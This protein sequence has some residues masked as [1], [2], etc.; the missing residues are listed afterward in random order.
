MKRGLYPGDVVR[1]RSLREV[2]ATLDGDGTLQ[3]LP[4]MPEMAA[5]CGKQFRVYRRLEKTCV[6]GYGARVLAD[7]VILAEARC[8]G[9][10]HDGCQRHCAL[11]WKEAW[12]QRV[13]RGAASAAAAQA[14]VQAGA[15]PAWRT[16]SGPDRYF[17]QS[18]ELGKATKYLFPISVKRCTAEYCARNFD[19]RKC[20][21]FLWIPLVV[22]IKTKLFGLR[23]VQPVGASDQTPAEELGL[24]PGEWIEVK[25]PAEIGLTLDRRGRNRGLAFTPQML[26]FCGRRYRV[27]S[28]VDRAI[29]EETGAMRQ[30]KNTVI[31]EEAVC[32]GHTIL[33]GCA[34]DV[35]HYWR[36][37]W[38]RRVQNLQADPEGAVGGQR[39]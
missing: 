7:T 8:D 22:K 37:I 19:W 5:F 26:P 16:K 31:L 36:E 14:Q 11:L 10:A 18:T 12:L 32:D 34:R 24:Q 35:Y 6:E 28:R 20:L 25:T 17:C 2:V 29:L 38:L 9:S 27:R 4:F 30:F 13:E 3:A 21:Q 33:G 23:A 1:V 39:R 15:A